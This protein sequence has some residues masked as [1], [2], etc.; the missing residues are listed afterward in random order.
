MKKLIL[1]A[2]SVLFFSSLSAQMS[3]AEVIELIESEGYKISHEDY[4]FL[5]EGEYEIT[6]KTFHTGTDYAIIAYSEDSEVFDIH[7]KLY[8]PNGTLLKS[9]T[10]PDPEAVI[11]YSPNSEKECKIVYK[12]YASHSYGDNII[13]VLVA[14]KITTNQL[15]FL[16]INR[17]SIKQT[18]FSHFCFY[19]GSSFLYKRLKIS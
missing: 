11:E 17:F 14:Y 1:F 8:S 19:N 2:V 9:D 10:A 4:A 5:E 13:R 6:Y 16:D 18:L 12:N 7:L 15:N 3:R